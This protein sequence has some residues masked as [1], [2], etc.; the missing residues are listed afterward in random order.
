MVQTRLEGASPGSGR[1][2]IRDPQRFQ[3]GGGPQQ[4]G[5]LVGGS[6]QLYA[7][8]QGCWQADKGEGLG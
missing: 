2:R 7:K 3:M 6:H 5:L 4:V 1:P 8:G